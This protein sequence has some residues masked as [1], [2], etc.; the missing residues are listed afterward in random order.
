MFKAFLKKVAKIVAVFA[1]I[2]MISAIAAI[3][4]AVT[5]EN[6]L[7]LLVSIVALNRCCGVWVEKEEKEVKGHEFSKK[8]A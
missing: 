5:L 7:L 6:V 2:T 4:Q 3:A 1:V 8:A